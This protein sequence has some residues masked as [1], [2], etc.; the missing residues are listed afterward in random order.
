MTL[1]STSLAASAAEITTTSC[2][3][4]AA[5]RTLAATAAWGVAASVATTTAAFG[6]F[7]V[8]NAF[9]H[10]AACGFGSRRHHIAARWLAGAAPDGLATHGDGFSALAGFGAKAFDDFDFDALLGEA[11]DVLH[12]AFFVHAHHCAVF[13]CG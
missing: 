9:H 8:A 5:W 6:L 10:F 3:C 1:S 2:R 13:I 7:L 11:L 4:I 12:E